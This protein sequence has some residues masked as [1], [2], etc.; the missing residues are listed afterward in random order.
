M[1]G[2]CTALLVSA[3][4]VGLSTRASATERCGSPLVTT[5]INSDTLWPHAGAQQ[6]LTVGGTETVGK[7]QV[8][9]GLYTS[10]LSRPISLHLPSPGAGGSD[11]FAVN[12]QVNGTFLW[13]YGVTSRLELDVALPVTFGQGGAG[14]EPITGGAG[15]QDTALRD[16]R[17]GAAYAVVPRARVSAEKQSLWALTA[18]LEMSAPTGDEDQFAGERAAVFMPSVAADARLGRLFAGAEVGARLRPT[19]E[20]VGARIGSQVLFGIGA[21]YDLLPRRDLLGVMYEARVLPILS[22][23]HDSTQTA[24]GL[25]STPNGKHL[26]PAEWSLGVRTAPLAGGDFAIQA[27]GGAPF[28]TDAP[29]TSPR[30]RF[31]LSIRYAPLQRD[32][33]GDGV[34]DRDD[35]CPHHPGS[36]ASGGC[37]PERPAEKPAF[38]MRPGNP[39]CDD[40]PDTVDGFTDEACPDEDADKDGIDDRHDICPAQA[41]DFAGLPDGCPEKR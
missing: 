39:A 4:F 13:A 23:Q 41:E 38:E 31:M 32:S 18:R 3:A 36:I 27:G 10:Y 8:A 17:F 28:T 12:D 9:F 26:F 35:S 40:D 19:A 22:E 14:V 24:Q 6:L 7:G 29:I 21:G 15:L 25:V 2:L 30:F 5:C 16:L 34:L 11:Q 20:L 33:D 37:E 1:R